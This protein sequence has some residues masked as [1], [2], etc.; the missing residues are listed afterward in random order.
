M[1]KRLTVLACA[2]VLLL[3]AFRIAYL[4]RAEIVVDEFQHLHAAYL[5][6]Q[7]QTPYVDFFEHHTPLFYYL[8]APLLRASALD[9]DT[10]L[11]ARWL[12][13]AASLLSVAIAWWW[14]RRL[15]GPAAGALVAVLMLAN[16]FLFARGTV[17]FL[18]VFACPY[19]LLSALLLSE[20]RFRPWIAFA[21]GLSFGAA[22]LLTQK[23]VMAGFAPVV[24]FASRG[25]YRG[26]DSDATGARQ[27]G[28]MASGQSASWMVLKDLFGYAAGGA[29]ATLALPALLGWGGLPAFFQDNVAINLV[30]K[31]RHFPWSDLRLL[32]ATDAAVYLLALL[33]LTARCRDLWRRRFRLVPDDVPA[34]F[35]ASLSL[36][37]VLLPVVWTEYFVSV[38][39]FAVLVAGLFL[40][41]VTSAI[42]GG[43]SG[44]GRKVRRPHPTPS[45]SSPHAGGFPAATWTASRRIRVAVVLVAALAVASAVDL[46]GR[47]LTP[48]RTL[49]AGAVLAVLAVWAAAGCGLT[50]RGR[51]RGEATVLLALAAFLALPLVEQGDYFL[52]QSNDAQRARLEFVLAHTDPDDAVFDGYSGYGV[53][54]PHA[55]KYWFLHDEVQLMLTEEELGPKVI[56]AIE[57]CRAAVVVLDDWSK[58]LPDMVASYLREKYE[59]TGFPDIRIRRRTVDD[60]RGPE[61]P[62]GPR[63]GL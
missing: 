63:S 39:S 35:L 3:V 21:S 10:V 62:A 2:F 17:L 33:G 53:F 23:S 57:Q 47:W 14:A 41:D 50:L 18:D 44:A 29:A 9:F 16:Y 13:L 43:Q 38:V 48:L 52:R 45:P 61:L 37:I 46:I 7:G 15:R 26:W 56:E 32:A 58:A 6:S 12:S 1:S 8:A 28:L 19:L 42:L 4:R 59:P 49:S 22:V 40:F 27:R 20:S 5:V 36:G 25:L 34:L 30:W 60:A 51:R 24:F 54:R 55:Y 31:A 11:S